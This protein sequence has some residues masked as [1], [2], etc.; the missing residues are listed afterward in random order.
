MFWLGE[1]ILE[2]A[3]NCESLEALKLEVETFMSKITLK[4]GQLVLKDLED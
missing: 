1:P 4:L 3:F 2:K